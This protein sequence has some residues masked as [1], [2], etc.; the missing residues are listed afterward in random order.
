MTA[1]RDSASEKIRL[2]SKELD[3]TRGAILEEPASG[4]SLEE[5][6]KENAQLRAMVEAADTEQHRRAS[7]V[8]QSQQSDAQRL[9]V[10]LGRA[11]QE[12]DAQTKAV[13]S[14]QEQLDDLTAERNSAA[15]KIRLLQKELDSRGSGQGEVEK[16]SAALTKRVEELTAENA[17]L[18]MLSEAGAG[19]ARL[20]D[21]QQA[22]R[23]QLQEKIDSLQA[24]LSTA[25][26]KGNESQ[27]L[28]QEAVDRETASVE[29]VRVLETELSLIRS[30]VAAGTDDDSRTIIEQMQRE[31][32]GLHQQ[33]QNAGLEV[34]QQR[35]QSV[36][37]ESKQTDSLQ[38]S[39][40]ARRELDSALA[41]VRA[42]EDA[43]AELRSERDSAA[44]KIITL[45]K[46][47]DATR[48]TGPQ[49]FDSG[50]FEALKKEN[51]QLRAMVESAD[52]DQ[53]RRAS[54]LLESQ[55]SDAQRLQ[56][57]LGR[58]RQ[59]LD[60][61]MRSLAIAKQNLED[62]T[63]ER[64]A[65]AEKIRLLQ[66]E[67]D[68]TRDGS[69]TAESELI[70]Q[71]TSQLESAR[72]QVTERS[73]DSPALGSGKE[74]DDA[75]AHI[76]AQHK[77]ISELKS[78]LAAAY[79]SRGTEA[80]QLQ[81]ALDREAAAVERVRI[82][83]AEL[84]LM[85][86]THGSA[87]HIDD[88]KRPGPPSAARVSTLD[89][90]R[91]VQL[92]QGVQGEGHVNA[93]PP[94][95]SIP[96]DSEPTPADE[97]MVQQLRDQ[98]ARLQNESLHSR[99]VIDG[100]RLELSSFD[101]ASSKIAQL[102]AEL[103]STVSF[104]DTERE[105]QHAEIIAL[106]QRLQAAL[107][108]HLQ[109][110]ESAAPQ[111]DEESLRSE[112]GTA[113]A[114]ISRLRQQLIDA[115][116]STDAF[117]SERTAISEAE[118]KIQNLEA[119]LKSTV[120]FNERE[121]QQLLQQIAGLQTQLEEARLQPAAD[122]DSPIPIGTADREAAVAEQQSRLRSELAA[123]RQMN[124]RLKLE[125]SSLD[126]AERKIVALE[127][128]LK[129]TIQFHDREK[130]DH[131]SQIF[132]LQQ[133]LEAATQQQPERFDVQAVEATPATAAAVRQRGIPGTAASASELQQLKQELNEA[134]A[135]I[136]SLE[137]ELRNT[138][139]FHDQE[140]QEQQQ[141][142][143]DLHRQV[144][145]RSLNTQAP[146]N[147][148]VVQTASRGFGG[149]SGDADSAERRIQEL[150][151]VYGEKILQLEEELRNQLQYSNH[152]AEQQ[153]MLIEKL[154]NAQSDQFTEVASRS[155]MQPLPT[156]S[157]LAAEGV[158][159]M[160]A[161]KRENSQLAQEA[162]SAAQQALIL[163]DE[164]RRQIAYSEQE[165]ARLQDQVVELQQQVLGGEVQVGDGKSGAKNFDSLAR[166]LQTTQQQAYEEKENLAQQVRRL[167][168][169]K[170]DAEA[171]LQIAQEE[172]RA[173]DIKIRELQIELEAQVE[174][175]NSEHTGLHGNNEQLGKEVD[176]LRTNYAELQHKYD[177]LRVQ[178]DAQ[179]A[180]LHD[181]LAAEIVMTSQQ[182]RDKILELDNELQ[183]QQIFSKMEGE[184]I[185]QE[186]NIKHETE[187]AALVNNHEKQV[188]QLRDELG[189]TQR[190]YAAER[191]TRS[192]LQDEL[193]ILKER[194]KGPQKPKLQ[195]TSIAD[196][197]SVL[198][199]AAP[200][201]KGASAVVSTATEVQ[202]RMSQL[203]GNPNDV[204][205]NELM[206]KLNEM[207]SN[208]T[209]AR[210]QIIAAG[211][212]ALLLQ[213]LQDPGMFGLQQLAALRL[214]ATVSAD[215]VAQAEIRHAGGL[216]TVVNCLGSQDPA[217]QQAALA[218]IRNLSVSDENE[219]VL[220]GLGAL[221]PVVALMD[222]DN[223]AVRRDAVK[224]LR[225]LSYSA[226]SKAEVRALG[227]LPPLINCLKSDDI[228]IRRSAMRGISVLSIAPENR[229]EIR[230]L[231]GLPPI[232]ECLKSGDVETRRSAAGALINLSVNARNKQEIRI[233]DGLQPLIL[234]LSVDDIETR[235]YAVRTLC[236]LTINEENK[237]EV[238]RLG[239]FTRMIDLLSVPDQTMRRYAARGL[240]HASAHQEAAV[241]LVSKNGLQPLL[242]CLRSK[243][244]ESI[245]EA[246]IALEHL[247]MLEPAQIAMRKLAAV[248]QLVQMLRGTGGP[249][250]AFTQLPAL[251]ILS[252]LSAEAGA[253]QDI[254]KHGAMPVLLSLLSSPFN[255]VKQAAVACMINMSAADQ[256][257][258]DVRVGDGLRAVISL[259]AEPE[260]L[261]VMDALRISFNLSTVDEN[262]V[263]F[264][265]LGG[266]P[267]VIVALQNTD[268]NMQR[269]AIKTLYALSIDDENE[270]EIGRQNGIPAVVS[271]LSSL[272]P[273][274]KRRAISCLC[275]LTIHDDNK[276]RVKE[277]N[278]IGLLVTCLRATDE[279]MVRD[280]MRAI[281]NLAFDDENKAEIR[282]QG[283]IDP[284]IKCLTSADP[285][286]VKYAIRAASILSVTQENRL[287]IS[288]AGGVKAV[289]NC[290][291][292]ADDETRRSAVGCLINLSLSPQHK[293]EV[294]AAGG[295]PLL[296]QCL[297][298]S[299]VETVRY[300]TRALSNLSML[301]ENAV[302]I[303]DL[304]G[305]SALLPHIVSKD[306][307]TQ[308]AAISALNSLA[309]LP[310][311]RTI[312][313]LPTTVQQVATCLI[314]R[315][316][317]KRA[318]RDALHVLNASASY[319]ESLP[320]MKD[321][322]TL[323]I[324]T[325]VLVEDDTETLR[326]AS[327]VFQRIATDVTVQ[328]EARRL[329]ALPRLVMCAKSGDDETCTAAVAALNSLAL[330][331]ENR[332]MLRHLDYQKASA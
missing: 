58:S 206:T 306:A 73:F 228:E 324:L 11:R 141:L 138:I 189:K 164:L 7:V 298:S 290:L 6:R 200:A 182:A 329:G 155:A 128:E 174:Y 296:V 105:E 271:C 159:K 149:G 308:R 49:E 100:L 179:L 281:R 170:A 239:G 2:L 14:L 291:A 326:V 246:L 146:P 99:E 274:T 51:A 171:A 113:R 97:L 95:T 134:D 108:D 158:A 41:R 123:A 327:R 118:R 269:L 129:S 210:S 45:Q 302:T 116:H 305:L 137:S 52:T 8:L 288:R 214:M 104:N 280:A 70:A 71:L 143:E 184:R 278:G 230:E 150:E 213:R 260:G 139:A 232:I 299:D 54:V 231:S 272:D 225:N 31:L 172:N 257:K 293:Q 1:E 229:V 68:A 318:R 331:Q 83:D 157:G 5:L 26:T 57:E 242:E 262:R 80:E 130:D 32:Q 295:L 204:Q 144:T 4:K 328:T 190:D 284:I 148:A 256:V 132:A 24:Q 46:E 90:A 156:G 59:D 47:L 185:T 285:M 133:L 161:L 60:Q 304:G 205:S 253:R 77:E 227:G 266:I 81:E 28:I 236:N 64:D 140:K 247:S 152:E 66:L 312:V 125:L 85:R 276:K 3:A 233:Q 209:E 98:I 321:V 55:Q 216:A 289:V 238:F 92:R 29:R 207:A 180:Q 89:D 147:T 245:K 96:S 197:G 188:A 175:A 23:Q 35:R 255:D 39:A 215:E 181:A 196:T 9:Q 160:E 226:E 48:N 53:H 16:P 201:K 198:G 254:I 264:R 50:K 251:K 303:V 22:D 311:S 292:S 114:E 199:R 67:L 186:L 223:Q 119:E 84:K 127:T 249:E 168:Q 241:E 208:Y 13:R 234:A 27:R 61:S 124:E 217:I 106:R 101:T 265:T 10:E 317:D 107:D 332:V 187:V 319:P 62:L 56:V 322:R 44:D 173:A 316:A 177:Q 25:Y 94:M 78:R 75:R 169:A 162:E 120:D 87:A 136:M 193:L 270:L 258:Q 37:F 74:L 235:R 301:E 103:R 323:Q 69:T 309:A 167:T 43:L 135:K 112:L 117:V 151:R 166:Q 93:G 20:S 102:E 315:R 38:D 19:Q 218:T 211:I 154:Q 145:E 273:E 267:F 111:T 176:E 76:S 275:N 40:R 248:R 277:A 121:H 122:P 15:E 220:V 63:V 36:M 314:E 18:R 110:T 115:E 330:D 12:A 165:I 79:S 91:D 163:Q 82:L 203:N 313:G 297:I 183:Q 192:R 325:D 240:A 252:Q 33:L 263:L 42:A 17:R 126:E 244:T 310:A 109:M 212:I 237:A 282:A 30:S 194:L 279:K 250:D 142:V 307:E 65:A 34:E 153:R 178:S 191:D 261:Y 221:P 259:L 219:K 88:D 287:A 294:R 21:L 86:T 300:T 202:W 283:G 224:T 243:D 320:A 222:S 268:E 286:T 195:S 131:V 72:S